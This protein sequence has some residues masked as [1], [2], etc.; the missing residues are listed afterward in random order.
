VQGVHG[1]P[2]SRVNCSLLIEVE[3]TCSAIRQWVG[4]TEH[5]EWVISLQLNARQ[6]GKTLSASRVKCPQ[7]LTK[8][9]QSCTACT[10][11]V[12][13]AVCVPSVTLMAIQDETGTKRCFFLKVSVLHY[14]LKSTKVAVVIDCFGL[15]KNM[16]FTAAGLWPNLRRLVR[17]VWE[18]HML[19]LS[20][21]ATIQGEIRTKT[22]SA[23]RVKCVLRYCW[24]FEQSCVGCGAWWGRVTC[25]VWVTPPEY[26]AGYGRKAI[27][28]SRVKCP[29]LQTDLDQS[30]IGYGAWYDC[31][32]CHIWVNP[33]Q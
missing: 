18:C 23:S 11:A 13:R 20:Y 6:V 19:N 16:L 3:Q 15:K 12:R 9:H 8:F 5:G 10:A 17:M 25:H 1:V 31:V 33:L 29:S 24:I 7:L 28:G 22:V 26:Q 32:T 14:W 30:P 4:S 21:P 27:S 2:F